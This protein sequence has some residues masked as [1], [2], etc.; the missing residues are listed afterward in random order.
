MV[1]PGAAGG[2]AGARR[3][4]RRRRAPQ[5]RPP[6]RLHG[7]PTPS[8]EKRREAGERRVELARQLRLR[9]ALDAAALARLGHHAAAERLAAV[10]SQRKDRRERGLQRCALCAE[11]AVR[12]AQV[13][14]ERVEG[15]IFVGRH[16]LPCELNALGVYFVA[17]ARRSPIF[18]LALELVDRRATARPQRTSTLCVP[19]RHP[20]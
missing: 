1:P 19:A 10:V 7:R 20:G 18:E 11:R 2:P 14:L 13:E 15:G 9:G 8:G 16:V 5:P 12:L 17:T 4:R 6:S 3:A